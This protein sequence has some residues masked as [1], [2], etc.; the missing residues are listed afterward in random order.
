MRNVRLRTSSYGGLNARADAFAA[1]RASASVSEK[2][3]C[4]SAKAATSAAAFAIFS[5]MD[6]RIAARTAGS[7]SMECC[8]TASLASLAPASSDLAVSI[9]SSMFLAFTR[10]VWARSDASLK[11]RHVDSAAF[12]AT[13]TLS[14]CALTPVLS[15]VGSRPPPA[16]PVS[17]STAVRSGR[18]A[19][20]SSLSD[21]SRSLPS[22]TTRPSS[23]AVSDTFVGKPKTFLT[24]SLRVPNRISPTSRVGARGKSAGTGFKFEESSS[25]ILTPSILRMTSCE[26][27]FGRL[28]PSLDVPFDLYGDATPPG[29]CVGEDPGASVTPSQAPGAAS[30][31]ATSVA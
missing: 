23:S 6:A 24:T 8:V 12:A 17:S 11:R 20:M 5:S 29:I 3:A 7:T 25:S 19:V 15:T 9:L 31:L 4:S 21:I 27:T 2:A 18:F 30:T 28:C 10:A 26:S 22:S 1:A 16:R 13:I 14:T